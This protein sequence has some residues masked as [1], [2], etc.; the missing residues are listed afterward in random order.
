M[1]TKKGEKV[2]TGHATK[3]KLVE[4]LQHKVIIDIAAG[5]GHNIVVTEHNKMYSWGAGEYGELGIGR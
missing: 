1:S 3:A 5:T 4:C 2:R